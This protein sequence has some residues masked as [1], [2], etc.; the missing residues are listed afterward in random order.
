MEY[1]WGAG[2]DTKGALDAMQALGKIE[3]GRSTPKF[4]RT[5]P[6]PEDRLKLLQA[7]ADDLKTKPRPQTSETRTEAPSLDLKSV[8]GDLANLE[9]SENPY[10]P[11]AVG[12]EWTYE[13][14]SGGGRSTYS[15]QVT[16]VVQVGE[17][18]VYRLMTTF[19]SDVSVSCQ[20]LTTASQAWRRSKPSSPD[21]P[22][23]LEYFTQ[24]SDKLPCTIDGRLHEFVGKEQ[25]VLPCGTFP[26]AI[27]IRKSGGT[28]A[29]T[30]DLYFVKGIGLARRVCLETNVTETLIRYKVQ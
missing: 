6:A 16:G 29:S 28:P 7:E 27:K 17:H 5:H 1:A 2:F 9:L 20:M 8:V 30:L 10:Y 3:K 24:A 12:D 18:K 4:L 14:Q 21:S 19:G 25:I 11:L 13:V 15:V 26:E 22:W 23:V